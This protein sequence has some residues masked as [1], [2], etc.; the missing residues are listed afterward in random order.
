[1]KIIQN[2][3]AGTL[4]SSD[5]LIQVN[6]NKSKGIN[7]HIDSVVKKQFGDEIRQLII[8]TLQTLEVDCCEVSVIDK[9]ALDFAIV[10]R[11]QSALFKGAGVDMNICWE[12]L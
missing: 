3:S 2:G 7:I 4:E 11:L 6:P 8:K 5:I 1:M 10:S 12:E 9:G